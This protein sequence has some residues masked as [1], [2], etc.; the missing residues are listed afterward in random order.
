MVRQLL[1]S[2]QFQDPANY[3]AR[4][5][6]PA[7][8]VARLIKEVG[9]SGFTAGGT[10]SPLINMGQT[11][12]EPPDVS[13]WALG[14]SWFSTGTMLARMNFA[15]TLAANQRFQLQQASIGSAQ[16]PQSFLAYFTDRMS[17]PAFDTTATDAMLAY[18]GA[19]EPWSGS[20]G[21]VAVKGAGLVH[22]IGAS[23]EY[24]FV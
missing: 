21:Q 9:W 7:E 16:S 8:Y 11:L 10:L 15:A 6:W 5:S 14:P 23:S 24:Q 1:Q 20:G 17:A 3:W 22:L 12:F 18:L 13:G 2:S 19:G 4:Y